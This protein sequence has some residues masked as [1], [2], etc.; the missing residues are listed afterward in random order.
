MD[1]YLSKIRG[2]QTR[3]SKVFWTWTKKQQKQ[4]EPMLGIFPR[5]EQKWDIYCKG[6]QSFTGKHQS[7]GSFKLQTWCFSKDWN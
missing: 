6:D 2:S 1:L 5:E 4:P 3:Y 7:Q